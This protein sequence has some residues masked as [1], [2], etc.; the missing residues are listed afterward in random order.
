M[1]DTEKTQADA[2]ELAKQIAREL[3][4]EQTK[5]FQDEMKKMQDEMSKMKE[6][7]SKKVEDAMS[8][9]DNGIKDNVSD[10]GGEK[11]NSHGKGIYSS[12]GFDCGQLIK[13]PPIYFPTVNHG[14]PP[15][16]DGTRYTDWAYKMKMHL[17][18][19]R[20]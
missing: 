11:E 7:L 2:A 19:A 18:A 20:L 6:E 15:H 3:M 4:D 8:A 16:F 14:K 13:G 12:T 17:I 1:S 9:K 5:L 10:I